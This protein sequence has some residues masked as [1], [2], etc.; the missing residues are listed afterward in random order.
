MGTIS[1]TLIVPRRPLRKHA[2]GSKSTSIVSVPL[3][4]GGR[5]TTVRLVKH[6]RIKPKLVAIWIDNDGHPVVDR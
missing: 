3:R 1:V 5:R 6:T 2:H 4:F